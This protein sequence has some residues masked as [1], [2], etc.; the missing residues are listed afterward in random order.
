MNMN[1][2]KKEKEE[3]REEEGLN[4]EIFINETRD[5]LAEFI[6]NRITESMTGWNEDSNNLAS[7]A[8]ISSILIKYNKSFLP[9]SEVFN[10]F[11]D[12]FNDIV[13]Y[14][15]NAKS[16]TYPYAGMCMNLRRVIFKVLEQNDDSVRKYTQY[17]EF[18]NLPYKLIP[19]LSLGWPKRSLF[20]TCPV[21][22]YFSVIEKIKYW[23][24]PEQEIMRIEL[25]EYINGVTLPIVKEAILHLEQKYLIS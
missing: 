21:P 9:L 6:N 14:G 17:S 22:G 2:I 23:E 20:W 5:F 10:V 15:K 3:R 8:T 11:E 24:D 25:A 7:L 4:Q 12:F 1:T 18:A 16:V 13:Q 19:I